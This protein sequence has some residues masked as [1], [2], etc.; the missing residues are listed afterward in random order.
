[1]TLGLT[2]KQQRPQGSGLL[3]LVYRGSAS[4]LLVAVGSFPA[5]SQT[6]ASTARP[7]PELVLQ[8]GHTNYVRAVAFSPDGRLLASASDDKTVKLW[9]VSTG[10][11]FRTLAGHVFRVRTVA[12][13]P[14]GR[15][16]ASGS[17]DKTVKLWDAATGTEVRTLVGHTATVRT[18]A[19]SPDGRWLASGSEDRTIRFWETATGDEVRTLLGHT[20]FVNAVAFSRDGRWL[21]SGADD[22]TVRLWEASTGAVYRIL[23]G[24]TAPVRA[25]VFS[26]NGAWLASASD[27]RTI[28]LWDV[29]DGQGLRTITAS[30]TSIRALAVSPDGRLLA[31]GG[32]DNAVKLWE[33]DT[34]RELRTLSGHDQGVLSVAFSP[35]GHWLASGGRDKTVRLWEVASGSQARNLAGNV[36]QVYKLVFDPGGGALAFASQDGTVRLWDLHTASDPRM[37]TG[38]KGPV[39]GVDFSPDRRWIA[40]AGGEDSTIKLCDA[41]TGRELRALTGHTGS[42]T[43]AFSPDGHWLASAGEDKTVRLWEVEAGRELRRMTGHSEWVRSVAFSPD[44]RWVA[45]GSEDKT[46]KLWDAATGR[47]VR[48]FAGH[49]AGVKVVAFSRDGKWFAS[50][51][52]DN[53]VKLWET[54]TGREVRT[55]SGHSRVVWALAFSPDGRWLASGSRDNTIRVWDVANGEALRVLAGHTGGAVGLS[56]SADGRWLASGS[57][58][59]SAR[60][61]DPATGQELALLCAKW[62]SSDWLVITPEG[63]FD[64]SDQ[65]MKQLVVWRIGDQTFGV[66]QFFADYYTPGLLARIF[67]GEQP[68]PAKYLA[69][70]KLP[71]RVRITSPSRPSTVKE[72]NAIV[73]V[74]ATEQGGGISEVR[75]YQNGKLVGTRIATPGVS[76]RA[77][78]SAT[79]DYAFEVELVP[80]E[81]VLQATAFSKERVQ[82]NGDTVRLLRDAPP[83]AQVN[84]HI[85]VVGINH[86][87]DPSFDLNFARQDGEAIAQFFEKHHRGLFSSINVIRLFDQEA[88]RPNILKSLERLSTQARPEDVVL[89]YLAGHGVALGEQFYLLPHEMRSEMDEEVAIRKYG[90][91]ASALGDTLRR[92]PA[93]KQ[94]LILDTCQAGAALPILAKVVMFRGPGT[95]ERKA[96]QMLA[97]ANG[98][99]LVAAS[100]KQ[101]YAVEVP[102]LGHGVLTYVLLTGLGEKGEPKATVGT[103]GVVTVYSLLQYAYQQVPEL[104]EKYHGGQKQYPV[105]F[106]TGMDFPPANAAVSDFATVPPRSLRVH[107]QGLRGQQLGPGHPPRQRLRRPGSRHPPRRRPLGL[108]HR[109]RGAQLRRLPLQ[110]HQRQPRGHAQAPRR[111][112]EGKE[113]AVE[114]L[115]ATSHEHPYRGFARTSADRSFH[116]GD[117][118]ARRK[119][120]QRIPS[121]HIYTGWHGSH[122]FARPSPAPPGLG[123]CH[124]VRPAIPPCPLRRSLP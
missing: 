100:T 85:L 35:D 53:T 105:S 61:W 76:Q 2:T 88:T 40:S 84:L 15:W 63:L 11:V 1:M 119:L 77:V 71:P 73:Q 47:E 83:P 43:V 93:L 95:A 81:N 107:G 87:E 19:F 26:S 48:T 56:W 89:V 96:T 38:H 50:G 9:E 45:S 115:H 7:T 3:G 111:G 37:L 28:R 12:F 42:V 118:E 31:S 46:V 18:L 113:A 75:L 10:R 86:Y 65:G 70:L 39:G 54:A 116:R 5:F 112:Q 51:S 108:P 64:G 114:T 24:H 98:V 103:E 121:P 60:I 44:G 25:A 102:E 41:A 27:D 17:E 101:Q 109:R 79:S 122:P 32:E 20:R 6:L 22:N 13:S 21:A 92:I 14:D 82:S 72:Q 74:E 123:W 58:D 91:S 34:G 57:G 36:G 99:Y 124:G 16:L 106:N 68:R 104:T 33:A 52:D 120:G 66:D 69:A 23:A 117:A 30:A 78:T 59:G 80:G 90:I 49:T 94:V 97:R 110:R 62:G 29:A 4:L 55:F 8:T 67:A